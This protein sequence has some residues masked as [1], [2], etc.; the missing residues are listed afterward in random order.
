MPYVRVVLARYAD[1]AGE[2]E[3]VR[4]IQ[5]EVVPA[6]RRRPGFRRYVSAVDRDARREVGITE[7]DERAHAEGLDEA[8]AASAARAAALGIQIEGTQIYEITVQA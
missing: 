6:L 7:W 2:Q 5:E 8:L 3:R 4:F 1:P